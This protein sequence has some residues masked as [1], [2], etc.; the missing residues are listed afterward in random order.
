MSENDCG[1]TDTMS[2]GGLLTT[3]GCLLLVGL[4]LDAVGRRTRLARISLLVVFGMKLG[5][6]GF[7]LLPVDPDGWYESLADLALTMIA[8][9]LGGELS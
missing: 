9:L 8:F 3:L 1:D 7:N 4:A 5:S 2:V 6:S